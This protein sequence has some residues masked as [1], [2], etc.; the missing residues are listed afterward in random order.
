MVA[1]LVHREEKG[2]NHIKLFGERFLK[3]NLYLCLDIVSIVLVLLE[4][5]LLGKKHPIIKIIDWYNSC[6]LKIFKRVIFA[7][8]LYL[9]G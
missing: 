2:F 8:S 1:T 4:M 9:E 6:F 3:I 7:F 5:R